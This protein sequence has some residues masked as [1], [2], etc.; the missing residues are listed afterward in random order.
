M[1]ACCCGRVGV[2]LGFW[3][4]EDEKLL[5]DLISRSR[6]QI[7]GSRS[8]AT[9]KAGPSRMRAHIWATLPC[10]IKWENGFSSVIGF[11]QR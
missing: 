9:K 6:D 7:L 11:R 4:F 8:P 2:S 10:L 1:P 5:E 3:F